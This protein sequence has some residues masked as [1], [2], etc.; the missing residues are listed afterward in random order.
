MNPLRPELLIKGETTQISQTPETDAEGQFVKRVVHAQAPIGPGA[1]GVV[2]PIGQLPTLLEY[3]TQV[4]EHANALKTNCASC[5]HWDQ[6]AWR[7]F[8]EASTG[9]AST[10]EDRQTIQTLRGRL[11]TDGKGYADANGNLDVEATLYSFGVCRVLS[12]WMEG[13]VGRNPIYW[14]VNPAPDATCPTDIQA[15]GARMPIVTAA[16]PFGLFR[17]RDQDAV[18][19]GDAKR[20]ALLF[21]AQGKT[22]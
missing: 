18:K 17:A 13:V 12:D 4:G 9:P 3:K 11:F 15:P 5:R 21:A 14:P 2:N 1:A 16:Q 8:V 22:R 20:D 6:K 7:K 10:V 19:T